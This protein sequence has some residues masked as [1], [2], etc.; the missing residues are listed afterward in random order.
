VTLSTLLSTLP[1]TNIQNSGGSTSV[2]A[3]L[4]FAG[5][6]NKEEKGKRG[7]SEK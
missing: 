7:G 6:S 4:P 2:F 1:N 3:K 5:E